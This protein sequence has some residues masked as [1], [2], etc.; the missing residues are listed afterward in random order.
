MVT[1]LELHTVD[2]EHMVES[3]SLNWPFGQLDLPVNVA[4]DSE[5]TLIAATR[6]KLVERLTTDTGKGSN[7]IAALT[8]PL[9]T[10]DS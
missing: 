9:Q 3:T 2:E 4:L 6:I 8:I 1:S 5:G 10:R 7:C